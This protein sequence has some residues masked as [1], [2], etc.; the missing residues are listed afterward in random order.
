M[1]FHCASCDAAC[2]SDCGS[3]CVT[4]CVSACKGEAAEAV[5]EAAAFAD[6]LL[7]IENDGPV[8]LICLEPDKKGYIHVPS[9]KEEMKKLEHEIRKKKLSVSYE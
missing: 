2:H 9:S 7:E 6:A 8:G 5:K 1:A 3:Q 4:A